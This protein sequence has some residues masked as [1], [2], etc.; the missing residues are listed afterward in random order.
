MGSSF[1][2]TPKPILRI[3]PSIV[4]TSIGDIFNAIPVSFIVHHRMVI[5]SHP[6]GDDHYFAITD[7]CEFTP[8]HS[9]TLHYTACFVV[10]SD[11]AS[12]ATA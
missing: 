9:F 4:F 7:K 6:A 3:V 10:L 5:Y 12:L 8:T 11:Y 1:I 2:S